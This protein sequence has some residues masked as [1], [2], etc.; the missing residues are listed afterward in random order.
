[1]SP[2]WVLKSLSGSQRITARCAFDDGLPEREFNVQVTFALKQKLPVPGR[3][4]DKGEIIRAA[5]LSEEWLDVGRSAA[6]LA[7]TPAELVGRR[8]KRPALAFR[9]IESSQVEVPKIVKR[10]QVLRLVMKGKGLDVS[11]Q[12][13]AQGEAG[14]GQT[15]DAI[16]PAT[17]KRLRVRVV[18][19]TTVEYA[20]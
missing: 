12:V 14:Y 11:G 18:D 7:Q 5:D 3:A 19:S 9:P 20:F 13:V 10:G 15:L 16:Y 1:V 8:L 17:K 4:M 6:K 2:D